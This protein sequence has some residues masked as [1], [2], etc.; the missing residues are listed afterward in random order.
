MGTTRLTWKL[1]KAG[2]FTTRSIYRLISFAVHDG[3]V[4]A[5]VM[6]IVSRLILAAISWAL[7]REKKNKNGL[8]FSKTIPKPSKG[9]FVLVIIYMYWIGLSRFKSITR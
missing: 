1:E 2:K 4:D 6:E 9:L 3:P 5:R 8:V 7:W